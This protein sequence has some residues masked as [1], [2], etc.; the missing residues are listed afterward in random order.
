[1]PAMEDK[2]LRSDFSYLERRGLLSVG[3]YSIL[4]KIFQ[5]FDP[6]AVSFINKVSEE[7]AALPSENRIGE[8]T[9]C[10]T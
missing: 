8:Q 2:G 5:K 1:M 4:N 10:F 7:M 3:R 6:R 9:W